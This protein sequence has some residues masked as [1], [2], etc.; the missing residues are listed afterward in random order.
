MALFHQ[1]SSFL[2]FPSLECFCFCSCQAAIRCLTVVSAL[3]PIAQ[4]NPS[5]SRATA[6]VIFLLSLPAAAS[7]HIAL[8]QAVLSLP[9]NLFGLFR[10]ALLSSAQS[11]PD[12]WWTMIAPCC[13]DNDSSQVRVAGFSDAPASIP[14][15][16]GVSRWAPRRNSPSVAEHCRSGIPGPTRPRWSQPRYLR[17][18]AA[19]VDR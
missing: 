17:C 18:R 11:I 3:V 15:A 4:M 1:V 5:S 7:S 12:T 19:P 14:L 10:N 16:T 6:V 8:V 13:F 9:C 2:L